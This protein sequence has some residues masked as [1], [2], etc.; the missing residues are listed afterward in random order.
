MKVIKDQKIVQ[1]DWRPVPDD[2]PLSNGDVIISCARW[3]REEAQRA[4]HQGRIAVAINGD[5]DL[6]AVI[7]HLGEFALIAIEFPKFV[8]GRGYSIARLLRERYGYQGELR[9]VG[10]VLRDQLYFMARC[11]IDSFAVREGKDIEEALHGF[12]ELSVT[13][14]GASDTRTPIYRQR[15]S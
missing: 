4:G 15:S 13:Y 11:G 9:A 2:E 3:Q 5:D 7:P 1:D 10:D 8:D 6:D 14:Q 12:Q